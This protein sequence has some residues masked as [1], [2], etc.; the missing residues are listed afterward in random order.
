MTAAAAVAADAGLALRAQDA[1]YDC[2]RSA[3]CFELSP[4]PCHQA[5]DI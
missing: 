5:R 4:S 1:M 3:P 2:S